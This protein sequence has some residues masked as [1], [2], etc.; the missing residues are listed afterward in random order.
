MGKLWM[1]FKKY[2]TVFDMFM[3]QYRLRN[4]KKYGFVRHVE[5]LL[6]QLQK[7]RF[8]E[9]TL[10]VFVA[11]DRKYSGC[12]GAGM[13]VGGHEKTF[14]NTYD[15]GTNGKGVNNNRRDA[16]K[17]VDVVNGREGRGEGTNIRKFAYGTGI[18]TNN[19][20]TNAKDN[21]V[22][23]VPGNNGGDDIPN[24][25]QRNER[26]IE[27]EDNEINTGLMGRS[28]MGEVK[29]MC[30]LTKLPIFCE[31]EGLNNVEIKLLGGLEVLVVMENEETE[32]NILKDKDH[33]LRRW[34]HKLRRGDT[35]NR[36][37]GRITWINIIGV[38]ISCWGETTFK[39]IAALHGSILGL[40]NCR[41]EGNQNMTFGRVQIHTIN[42]G[43]INEDLN[44]KCKGKVHK[45][46]IVEEV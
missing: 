38:P 29:A 35:L 18:H 11:Y 32:A 15:D 5:G 23:S 45:V 16:R 9:E 25:M 31:E 3:V 39:K 40:Q 2:G 6:R 37:A 43:L 14:K 41:V 22:G 30:F 34:I 19:G 44:I 21:E 26:C 33:G 36:N 13:D 10:R 42:K 12:G 17:F 8:G 24:A 7:I 4:G 27:I 1:I 46:N 28:V 20:G